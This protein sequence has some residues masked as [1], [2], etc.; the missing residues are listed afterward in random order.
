[1][2]TC[3]FAAE[4]FACLSCLAVLSLA[5]P[6]VLAAPVSGIPYNAEREAYFGDLH[7]HTSYSM[8]AYLVNEAQIDPD[9]AYRF[10]RGEPGRYLDQEVTRSS[11]PLDFLAVADHSEY[12]GV[13]NTLE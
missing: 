1:M 5:A 6:G 11:P 4:S 7:L 13:F 3:R 2:H 10:A 9:H 8:D 12:L